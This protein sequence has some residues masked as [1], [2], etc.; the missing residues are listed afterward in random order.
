MSCPAVVASGPSWPQPVIRAK[1][2][3]G[4]TAAHSSG[5]MPSRSQVPGRKQS[6][7]TSALAAR[8]SSAC[9]SFLTSRS[10]RRLPRC[11][12]SRSSL[13]MVRPPGP[14]HPDHVG[15]EVGQHHRR[16]RSG[17]DAAQFDDFHPGQGSCVGH[18]WQ[19]QPPF[20]TSSTRLRR[21]SVEVSI[22]PL[23]A[24]FKMNPGSGTEGSMV[25]SNLTRVLSPSGVRRVLRVLRSQLAR[26]DQSP[27]RAV[28]GPGVVHDLLV[29][30]AGG[31][32]LHLDPAGPAVLAA[33]QDL[34]TLLLRRPLG[35]RLDVGDDVEDLLGAC[36]DHDLAGFADCH[37]RDHNRRLSVTGCFGLFTRRTVDVVVAPPESTY[38]V[39]DYLLDR[40]AEL[41]VTEVFGVP[42]D[43]NLEFLDHVV[44]HPRV[45][46]VGSANELN[47]GYAADGYGRLRGMS[48]LVTTFGVG[49]LSR[50]QRDRRQLRRARARGAHRRRTVEGRP[51]RPA[52][53]P[54]LARRR[55]LRA[56]LADGTRD[57]LRASQ[58]RSRDGDPR[59]RPGAVGGA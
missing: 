10:T 21:P 42:G 9:G 46:W 38:T 17:A 56:F 4:L 23:M 6:S 35:H 44:A 50:R 13:G 45:R 22:A 41:G 27:A 48:A 55:R 18:G 47:A 54:S 37:G 39:G 51:G 15:P 2:S 25:S 57:H 40:L 7:S 16:V 59:D 26:A 43:Y 52:G 29:G 1:I 33:L 31:F 3:R 5:P 11:S 58:S 53:G 32:D 28:V 8:S 36:L 14:A 20:L 34:D 12:R 30:D 19:N 49:E 24:R